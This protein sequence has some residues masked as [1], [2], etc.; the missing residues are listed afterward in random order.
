MLLRVCL[1]HRNI[2]NT[3][4]T[5]FSQLT[6]Q[7]ISKTRFSI[8]HL[9]FF[10]FFAGLDY[11][12]GY[13]EWSVATSANEYIDRMS[14]GT[15]DGFLSVASMWTVYYLSGVLLR[16]IARREDRRNVAATDRISTTLDTVQSVSLIMFTNSLVAYCM[17]VIAPA[18]QQSSSGPSSASST[19]GGLATVAVG[20]IVSKT[21]V[22]IL[23]ATSEK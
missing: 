6:I 13:V 15:V 18:R 17:Q 22:K 4:K 21:L 10:T 5:R 1:F 2:A 23:T 19:L 12:Q 14:N 7:K 20:I 11:F 16:E 3:F 8:G 9:P